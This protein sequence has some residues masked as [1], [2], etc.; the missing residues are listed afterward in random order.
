[1]PD[2]SV[3]EIDNLRRKGEISWEEYA[4][5]LQNH[6]EHWRLFQEFPMYRDYEGRLKE[7]MN[8]EE[9]KAKNEQT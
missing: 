3:D 9:P 5:L 7:L 8:T 4:R 1:M 2:L 6:P